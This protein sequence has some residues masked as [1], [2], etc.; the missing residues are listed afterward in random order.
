PDPLVDG[1]R[2]AAHRRAQVAAAG[3]RAGLEPGFELVAVPDLDARAVVVRHRVERA[4]EVASP[5]GEAAREL[6]PGAANVRD[7]VGDADVLRRDLVPLD[8]GELA[9]PPRWVYQPP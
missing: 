5:Q 8:L 9:H 4:I 7:P 1:L 2:T 3:E 6:V